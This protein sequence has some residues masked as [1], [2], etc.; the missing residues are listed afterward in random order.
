ER[1]AAH[2]TPSRAQADLAQCLSLDR[3]QVRVIAPDVGG[4]F[5]AKASLSPEDF[6]L[7]LAARHAHCA[8]SWHSSRSEEF[9][10][11]MQG[12]GSEISGSLRVDAQGNFLAL[13]A[14]L[15]FSLGAW[16]PYS[17]LMPLRN[18]ARMLPGPYR[19]SQVQVTS[20]AKGSH[21]A[22]VNI[23]RGAGRPEAALLME[24]LVDKA[25]RALQIDPVKLRLR[26]L[27]AASD[28][29]HTTPSGEL[30]DSGDYGRALTSACDTLG[31]EA[32]R[33]SQALRRQAGEVV[34]I[35][36]A[37][38]VEPCGQG[39]EAA[40]VSLQADGRITV[41]SGSPAQ[42]QGHATSF[43]S[44]AFEVLSP[45]LPCKLEDIEVL[46]GDTEVC[47]EGIG[48]LA[49]RSMAIGGSAIVQ[50]CQQLVGRLL[51]GEPAP[52]TV[53]A[54]FTAKEAWSYG[55]VIACVAIDRDTGELA[56][57]RIV[58]A[59]DA[60]SIISPALA[61]GQLIGGLA[62]GLGQAMMECIRYDAQGQLLTGSLMDYAV[63]RAL[64]LPED[65][66]IVS[67]QTPSP[68]NLLGA[69][70]VGEAGC[71]GVPAALMNAA[72]DA[73]SPWGEQDLSFPLG[74]EQLWR[75]MTKAP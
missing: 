6:A 58:W 29:P 71:I 69:K 48:A 63:P 54:Q 55:C 41:A 46:L 22:A 20:K 45:H 26:N 3:S 17:A 66:D 62:Q 33:Q 5:G 15:E 57:E 50:A 37:M 67:M 40:R 32:A 36:V 64:D 35:G 70:G 2:A 44:I 12:R 19:L 68:N 18:A 14:Q 31:Y 24:T 59:D 42:G 47:P 30:L 52:I 65:I 61:H 27:L 53:D 75:C 51:A 23:Y 34:G 1:L 60:G 43:A 72:R 7:A 73:L 9:L 74:A 13:Q 39:W 16:L 49:S 25:A 10:S 4:A 11:G 56:I 28:L 8:L 21:T 38:Y